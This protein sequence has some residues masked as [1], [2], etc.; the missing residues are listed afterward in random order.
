M[1][2][3]KKNLQVEAV[4]L[5]VCLRR[6]AYKICLNSR[7]SLFN[8]WS[9][10]LEDKTLSTEKNSFFLNLPHSNKCKKNKENFNCSAIEEQVQ[11]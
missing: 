2:K 10:L 6:L 1:V 9:R 11:T 8:S 5:Y 3:E 7:W 4:K